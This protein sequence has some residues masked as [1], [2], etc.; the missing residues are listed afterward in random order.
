ME[1][2]CS[3]LTINKITDLSHLATRFAK[4][5]NLVCILYSPYTPKGVL[6]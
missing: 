6:L 3:R 4:M 1:N 5:I 2:L